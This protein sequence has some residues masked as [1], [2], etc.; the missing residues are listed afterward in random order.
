MTER[1]RPV[2]NFLGDPRFTEDQLALIDERERWLRS[3]VIE[4]FDNPYYSIVVRGEQEN[5]VHRRMLGFG[6]SAIINVGR[7]LLD[8]WPAL[9]AEALIPWQVHRWES[10][11]IAWRAVAGP[12]GEHVLPDAYRW[13]GRYL[14]AP[15]WG[16]VGFPN[17]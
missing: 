13:W 12:S 5:W 7:M 6:R 8:Y 3:I 17:L 10:S 15:L 16:A 9:K 14:A 2:H 11:D 1:Q 4:A